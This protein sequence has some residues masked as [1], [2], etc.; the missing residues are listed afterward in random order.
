[1]RRPVE[2]VRVLAL[3]LLGLQ[4]HAGGRRGAA[5]FASDSGFQL[6]WLHAAAYPTSFVSDYYFFCV[7][8]IL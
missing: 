3:Q 1:M 2:A 4:L 6:L 5:T 8:W 7:E